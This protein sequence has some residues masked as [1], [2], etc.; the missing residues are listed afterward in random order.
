MTIVVRTGVRPFLLSCW[1]LTG[2]VAASSNAAAQTRAT[3]AQPNDVLTQSIARLMSDQAA[4]GFSGVV[5]VARGG[6]PIFHQ[7]YGLADNKTRTA[8][9]IDTMIDSG[10]LSKQVTAAAVLKLEAEGRLSLN[11]PL[12]KFFTD[13]P[14]DKKPITLKQ[15]LS[16]T[17]GLR[18]WVLSEDFVYIPRTAWLNKVFATPL[19]HA[20]GS[21]F[22]YSND[23]F[24]LAAMVVEKVSGLSF[25]TYIHQNFFI[26]LGMRHSGWYDDK[27]FRNSKVALA[28]GYYNG[29][30]DGAPD[31]WPGPYWALLGNGGIVWNSSDMLRWHRAING[32]LLPDKAKAE[33]FRPV[34][35]AIEPTPYQGEAGALHYALGWNVGRT[36]CGDVRIGHRGAGISHNVDY[37]FYRDRDLLVYVASNKLDADHHGT[38]TF[39]SKRAADAI[40]QEILKGCAKPEPGKASLE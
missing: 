13:V 33:F 9:H 36:V 3:S 7:A 30:D 40:A 6:K 25:K 8:M 24:T 27:L 31:Q 18:S 37:R 17:S 21:K 26:P 10:S 4:T 34:A 32:K 16:H 28:T 29:K 23:G 35:L 19:E 38:E 2:L 39:Y 11:D 14:T 5:M 22:L 1:L 20:P 12:S 15:L